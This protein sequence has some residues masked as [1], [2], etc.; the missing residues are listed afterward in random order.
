MRFLRIY[1]DILA[2]TFFEMTIDLFDL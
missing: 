1:R 2:L